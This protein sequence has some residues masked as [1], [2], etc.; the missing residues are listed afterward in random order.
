MLTFHKS[1]EVNMAIQRLLESSV[2]MSCKKND[3]ILADWDAQLI[4]ADKKWVIRLL[5]FCCNCFRSWVQPVFTVYTE[6][7]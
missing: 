3:L 5:W 1:K 2:C 7:V 6:N 4:L